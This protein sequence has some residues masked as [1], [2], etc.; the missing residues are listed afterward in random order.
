MD[1]STLWAQEN[2]SLVLRVPSALLPEESNVVLNPSHPEFAGVSMT[3]LRPFGYD[4]R[5]YAE[6]VGPAKSDKTKLE[7]ETNT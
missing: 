5:M 4:E 1:F 3:V 2:R 6:R 7:C